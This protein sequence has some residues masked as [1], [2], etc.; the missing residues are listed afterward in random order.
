[1]TSIIGY[2]AVMTLAVNSPT[3]QQETPDQQAPAK[4]M[5]MIYQESISIA[6][7]A[8]SKE[9]VTKKTGTSPTEKTKEKETKLLSL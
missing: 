7:K 8:V 3:E 6:V 5:G 1:M 4:N 9:Q 2:F